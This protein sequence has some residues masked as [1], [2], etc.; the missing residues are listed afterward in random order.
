M[1][2]QASVTIQGDPAAVIAAARLVLMGQDFAVSEPQAGRLVAVGP[3][4]MSARQPALRGVSSLTIE[5]TGSTF[6]LTAERR[7]VVVMMLFILLFP[8]AL[9]LV[10]GL[11][12]G[13]VTACLR[14]A[15]PWVVL[16]PVLSLWLWHRTNSALARLVG[17][18]RQ[19]CNSSSGGI[20]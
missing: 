18:L 5:I 7:N 1:P 8:F 2:Y 16:G 3:R 13:R 20:R 17:N 9:A 15:A 12:Q 19:V 14:A 4:M 10:L 6:T 11:T